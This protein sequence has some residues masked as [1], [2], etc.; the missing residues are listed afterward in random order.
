MLLISMREVIRANSG[1]RNRVQRSTRLVLM[2][3]GGKDH[4][5]FYDVI[6]DTLER[7]A[8]L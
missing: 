8:L 7:A 5:G 1:A 3:L 4:I 2:C 6:R